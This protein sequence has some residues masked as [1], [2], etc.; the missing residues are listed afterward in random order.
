L[1]FMC[2]VPV[3]I[4]FQW[5]VWRSHRLIVLVVV[6]L[7]LGDLVQLLNSNIDVVTD[8]LVELVGDLLSLWELLESLVN[9]LDQVVSELL[10][11]LE[12]LLKSLLDADLEVIDEGADFGVG[13]GVLFGLEVHVSLLGEGSLK[14]FLDHLLA[15]NLGAG[16]LVDVWDVSLLGFSRVGHDVAQLSAELEFLAVGLVFL[17]AAVGFLADWVQFQFQSIDKV[18][19]GNLAEV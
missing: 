6:A 18:L 7:A 9:G 10:T 15:S 4:I 3:V 11:L 19:L 5:S 14:M 17:L 13:H 16:A 1:W 12:S 2:Y 8:D